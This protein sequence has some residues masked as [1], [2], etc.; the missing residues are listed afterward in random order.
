MSAQTQSN[1]ELAVND[2][3]RARKQ[4]AIQQLLARI[5]GESAD[6]LCY[7]TVRQQ[8]RAT[9]V[10]IER[11]LQEI[12]LDKIVGSVGRYEDFTRTYFPK[13]DSDQERWAG[14]KAAITDMVGMPPIDV[15]QLGD[16]YFVQ[17]GNHRV[18]VARQLGSETI[19]AY[20]T[21][22]KTRV[23][24]TA[25]DDP[26][27]LICKSR[28]AEFLEATN[29]DK[30]RPDADLMMTF[31]GQFRVLLDQ[32]ETEHAL[33]TRNQNLADN[34]DAWENAV[35]DWYDHVYLPVI[36]II[37]ALGILRRFPERTEADMYVLL[38]ERHHELEEALGWHVEMETAVTELVDSE[39]ESQ[40]LF[41]RFVKKVVPILDRGPRPG[42]WRKQQLARQRY[43]H[44]FA[45]ILVPIDGTEEGWQIL[46]HTLQMGKLD[47]DHILGLHIVPDETQLNSGAINAMRSRFEQR[48]REVGLQGDFAVDVD[49]SPVQAIIRRAAWADLV[50]AQG[51]RPSEHQ[52]L[53]RVSPG[54]KQLIQHCPRPIEVVP[55]GAHMVGPDSWPV[56]LLL[57]YDGSPKANEALFVAAYLTARWQRALTVISVET[58][59]TTSATLDRA[60]QYLT[61][62]EVSNVNYLLKQGPIAETVL[63]TA[64]SSQS[65]LLIMGGFS[66]QPV[67]HLVLGSTAEHI[68]R[69]FRYPMLICR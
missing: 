54:L 48:C 58:V 44:L 29:L 40:G 47:Q 56:R 27:V 36:Q 3:Q 39:E 18:S 64:K 4:A 20:V 52:P 50:I 14:V 66:F 2:F 28:Y 37:R 7:D 38:S 57:A 16:T 15:Y 33:L 35:I 8:L 13:R 63:E 42:L 62:H 9:E 21:E 61:E 24:L 12:P 22:V 19:S 60:R 67:R 45:D 30:L 26:N 49:S 17:D 65:Q 25:D 43:H 53:P 59:Y 55:K 1:Y 68:L 51:A 6:L 10:T 23:P 69:E 34:A 11:G 32:I 31:C 46:D 5:R 41:D